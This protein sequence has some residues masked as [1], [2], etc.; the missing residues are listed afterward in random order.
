MKIFTGG[1]HHESDTFNPIVT[2]IDDIIVRRGEELSSCM[3][4]DSLYGINNTLR[5]NG[6]SVISSLH[7]RAVPNGEWDKEAYLTLKDEF[8]SSLKKALPV[9]GICLALHGSMRV[10]EI[11]KAESDL[12]KEI[13]LLCPNVPISV[14]LDM[15]ATITEEMISYLDVAVG[16]K[17]APHTDTIETGNVAANL[18]E[19]ILKSK[20]LYMSAYRISLLIAGEKSETSTQPMKSIMDI[21]RK[22]EKEEGVESISLFMGFPWADVE[23][24][25]VTALCISSISKEHASRVA[26]DIANTFISYKDDFKFCSEAYESHDSL[27]KCKEYILNKDFPIII[28]DSGDN[29]TAGSSGDVT[30]FLREILKDEVLTTLNPPLVYQGFYDPEVV[31]LAFKC[32]IGSTIKGFLGAKFDK[33]KSR[34]IEFE[35]KVISLCSSYNK[36]RIALIR[37]NGV[38]IVVTSAHVGCYEVEMMQALGVDAK[39]RKVIVVKLGYLEPELK[40]ICNKAILALTDGSSNELFERLEY[41]N[42]P[43]PFYPLDIDAPIRIKEIL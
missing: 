42:L 9:G 2:T 43:R 16:Y 27:A 25:G 22:K 34:P 26:F 36:N 31:E 19:K 10:K 12:L 21:V 24:N 1:F 8:L 39:D 17:C 40:A 18:L 23:E 32:G 29:P 4:E 38:D 13:K 5:E 37:I 28:S 7:A 35:G 3:R 15:H 11:G 41:K 20:K 33:I 30:N 14:A 6:H